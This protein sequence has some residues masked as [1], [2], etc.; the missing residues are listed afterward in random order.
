MCKSFWGIDDVEN[1][2]L[3]CMRGGDSGCEEGVAMTGCCDVN[4]WFGVC[5][6][7]EEVTLLDRRLVI[8]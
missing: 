1:D 4:C 6:A 2:G 3:P 5:G 8:P 7:L